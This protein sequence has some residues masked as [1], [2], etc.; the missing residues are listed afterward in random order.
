MEAWMSG[1]VGKWSSLLQERADHIRNVRSVAAATRIL[2]VVRGLDELVIL[3]GNTVDSIATEGTP[4]DAWRM[5]RRA[6]PAH[7]LIKRL[8]QKADIFLGQAG[9][10]DDAV[11][12]EQLLSL[13]AI[14]GA[15]AKRLLA[16]AA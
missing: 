10:A 5:P 16:N 13:S 15:E 9:I 12:A 14:F 8:E 4:G 1:Q 2:V 3:Y 11:Q 6:D 7:D